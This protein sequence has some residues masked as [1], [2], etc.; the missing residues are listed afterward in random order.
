MLDPRAKTVDI[1]IAG[2]DYIMEQS[3]GLLQ[4]DRSG[5]TTGAAVWRTSISVAEW[6]ASPGNVLFQADILDLTSTVLELGSGISG[7][8]AC[9]LATRV[10]S[11][12]AT[13]QQYALKLLRSNIDANL[14][15]KTRVKKSAKS[16]SAQTADIRTLALDWETDDVA[17]FL[18]TNALADGLDVVLASDC[19][20]NY[21]L[22]EP[23]SQTYV[24][25]CR[26]R[27][28]VYASGESTRPTICVIAQQLRQSM[29][30]ACD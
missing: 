12:V 30:H 5:G 1:T 17:S 25:I 7:L 3:P 28:N 20:Y 16:R 15:D 13:D 26:A 22:I 9:V 6:L 24:D 23:L 10:K 14:S 2:R 21:A 4:S 11:F 18:S 19:I 29:A 8:T 27:R